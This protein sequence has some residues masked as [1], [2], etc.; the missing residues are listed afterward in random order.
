MNDKH[1]YRIACGCLKC[2]RYRDGQTELNTLASGLDRCRQQNADLQ[3]QLTAALER[4]ERLRTGLEH[5]AKWEWATDGR[6]FGGDHKEVIKHLLDIA[7]RALA[8]K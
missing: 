4:A 7:K 1:A 3:S 2:L 5:I 6:K 8:T